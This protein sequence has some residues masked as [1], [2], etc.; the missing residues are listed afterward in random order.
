MNSN[1]AN[2][3]IIAIALLSALNFYSCEEFVQV[4]LPNSQISNTSVFDSDEAAL[5]AATSMFAKMVD[6][7]SLIGSYRNPLAYLAGLSAD[8]LVDYTGTSPF[9]EFYSNEL[10]V[11]NVVISRIWSSIYNVIYESNAIIEGVSN[12]NALSRKTT[13]QILGEAKF[14][15]ALC[16]FYLV[17]LFGDIPLVTSTDYRINAVKRR[18]TTGE[19]YAQIITDLQDA[20]D[21]LV[22]EYFTPDR[23]RPNR[24]AAQ[25]LLSRVY[26]YLKDYTNA[27]IESTAVLGTLTTYTLQDDLNA[28]FLA[29]SSESVWELSQIYPLG[30]P[31]G[32]C[33]IFTIRNVLFTN[34]MSPELLAS[35]E[36]GDKRKLS[37]VNSYTSAKGTFY[38][39]HKYKTRLYTADA[40]YPE[41][42]VMLR[43]G[44]LYLIRSEARAQL[45]KLTDA[46]IDLNIIRKRAGLSSISAVDKATIL[47]AIERERRV[48][49]FCEMGH[50]WFDL[51]RYGHASDALSSIKPQWSVYKE[52][53][54][55]PAS[56]FTANPF[57][58]PQNSGY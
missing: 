51:K 49:L 52:L 42:L 10:N 17:N 33:Q 1:I 2:K 54:P 15:R 43:L 58:Q 26:L 41:N 37:W 57:L 29:N 6:Q 21:L 35:F 14:V 16:H 13:N 45:D 55:I 9:G 34:S 40:A 8:E 30:Y 38:F 3:C 36:D 27:E 22:V 24:Y 53:Y 11:N 12:S 44:E 23:T 28:V 31:T 7:G 32:D 25:A 39:S 56:E 4:D 19:V 48:E 50:R 5:G 46:L 20:K 18:S 47:D